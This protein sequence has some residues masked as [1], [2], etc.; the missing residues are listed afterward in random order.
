MV[1]MATDSKL[2][3]ATSLVR[4]DEAHRGLGFARLAKRIIEGFATGGF[5]GVL[6]AFSEGLRSEGAGV[7]AENSAYLLS[8]VIEEVKRL[9]EAFDQ[10]SQQHREFLDRDWIALLIDGDDKARATRAKERVGRIAQILSNSAHSG[11][12]MSAD[13][14]EEMMRVAMALSDREVTILRTIDAVQSSQLNDGRVTRMQAI[15]CWNLSSMK[16]KGLTSGEVESACSK[17]QSFGLLRP[18]EDRR[19]NNLADQPIA[20]GLLQKG[21]DFVVY[22]K[23]TRGRE[24][25]A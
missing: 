9:S 16:A 7:S 8:I 23:A 25:V 2:D 4:I 11:P 21:H 20:Y 3:Q 15:Q 17:L 18:A 24:G 6:S 14:V 22:I 1:H 13:H 12:T 19:A 10:L 5:V